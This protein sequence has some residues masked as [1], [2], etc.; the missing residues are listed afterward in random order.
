MCPQRVSGQS[1]CV[2]RAVPIWPRS[3]EAEPSQSC[4]FVRVHSSGCPVLS[5]SYFVNIG[6]DTGGVGRLESMTSRA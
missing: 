4:S 5:L 2:S 3:F 1:A 6:G